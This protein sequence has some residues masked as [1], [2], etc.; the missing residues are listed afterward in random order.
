LS[1]ELGVH[2]VGLS[3]IQT[4]FANEIPEIMERSDGDAEKIVDI[5]I[6]ESCPGLNPLFDEI[7]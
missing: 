2:N 5:W 4:S 6:P 1:S 3:V 7:L